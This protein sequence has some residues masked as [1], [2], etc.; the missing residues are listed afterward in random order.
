MSRKLAR[1]IRKAII[2]SK[3]AYRNTGHFISQ[4]VQQIFSLSDD[5]YPEI[6]VQPFSGDIVQEY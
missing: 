3:R 4:G 2:I 5:N 6:G 1:P